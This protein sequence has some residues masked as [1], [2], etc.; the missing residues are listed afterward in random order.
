MPSGRGLTS[1]SETVIITARTVFS[2]P[3]ETPYEIR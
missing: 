2:F 3:F 1:Y